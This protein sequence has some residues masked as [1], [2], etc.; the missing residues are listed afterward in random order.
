M[1]HPNESG[2]NASSPVQQVI[3]RPELIAKGPPIGKVVVHHHRVMQPEFLDLGD[4]VGLDLFVRELR[5]MYA[6]HL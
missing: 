2:A 3:G 5:V 6:N 1:G 4:H